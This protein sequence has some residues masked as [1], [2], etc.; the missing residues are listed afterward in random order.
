MEPS[1]HLACL[2]GECKDGL[3]CDGG[4]CCTLMNQ[5]KLTNL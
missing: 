5:E 4:K 3:F 1:E 2:S